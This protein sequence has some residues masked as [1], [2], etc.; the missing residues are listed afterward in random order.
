MAS[1]S[2]RP[3][4]FFCWNFFPIDQLE[5]KLIRNQNSAESF[6]SGSTSLAP[7]RNSTPVSNLVSALDSTLFPALAPALISSNKLFK[8]FIKAYLES[9]Q[10]SSRSLAECKQS[11]EAKIPDVYYWKLHMDCY[12]FYQQYKDHF[13][14]AKVN[15]A[16]RTPFTTFFLCRSIRVC[17]M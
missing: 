4:Y 6:H 16:K 10:R 5:D 15:E 3:Y 9:N 7:S 1:R 14:T 17:W 12:Y 8:Q 13:H 2:S 11:L